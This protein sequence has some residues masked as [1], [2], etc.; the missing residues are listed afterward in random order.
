MY[1]AAAV[2]GTVFSQHGTDEI[3]FN[4]AILGQTGGEDWQRASWAASASMGGHA[5][6]SPTGA[7]I[8]EM[9][10]VLTGHNSADITSETLLIDHAVAAGAKD[11]QA[12][13]EHIA[14]NISAYAATNPHEAMAEAFADVL[15]NGSGASALS[16]DVFA[17]IDSYYQAANLP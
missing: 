4:V 15:V 14:R 13:G 17:V 12:V 9:G 1:D 10:H 11:G 16:K 5:A 3:D 8:H 6:P 7:A 2:T